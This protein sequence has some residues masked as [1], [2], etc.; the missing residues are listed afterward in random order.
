M[1]NYL[2]MTNEELAV[3]F[4]SVKREFE[5]IKGANLSLDMSRGKPGAD[6]LDLSDEL[7]TLVSTKAGFKSENGTETRNYGVL[8]G[9]SELK[10]LF[11]KVLGMD[12]ANV[13]CG[14]N[15]SLNMMFDTITQGMITGFG[16]GPWM[17][18][19][20]VKFICP[21]PGYDRHFGICEYYGIEMVMV[22]NTETGP[23]MD[24][25]EELVKDP[26]VKGMWCV[27]KYSNPTGITY[28]DETVKRIAALKPAAK[29]FR[30]MWD[31]AYVVH[32][33]YNTTDPL[34][35][36]YEECVKN[37][38]E[39]L[40]FQFTSTS[41]ITYPGA[42]VAVEAA[43]PNN[44]KML[45]ARMTV[46]TIGPDKINQLCH[47]KMLPS[48][49]ALYEQMKKHADILRPKF[50][51]V[52]SVLDREL[53]GLEIG[54][55]IK[56]RGGYFISFDA[57]PGCAKAIVAKAKEAGVVMTGA[58]ATFP[59]GKDPQDSNIRIAPSFPTPEELEVAA[60]IFVLSVKLVSIDKILAEK[61]SA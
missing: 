49:E 20:K 45:K 11:G 50:E 7:L 59:Y 6:Q 28:S 9:L 27:P 58:G 39:D 46:Q 48:L 38:N 15:S 42:G 1:A 24:A 37:G 53:A 31:N 36:I 26:L 40:V 8:D 2:S 32:D 25:V 23:D 33:L 57:L 44:I 22:R 18:Q 56:P 16:E 29:D 21:A 3:E 43:S 54:S 4:D 19:G 51:A 30:V 10:K 12:S 17:T 5:K 52:L 47:A 60:D 35:N 41:K 55:W 34:L 13:I 14:G 61:Q